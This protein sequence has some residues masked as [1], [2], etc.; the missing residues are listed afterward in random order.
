MWAWDGAT[1]SAAL[2]HLFFRISALCPANKVQ[3]QSSKRRR[4]VIP[5]G[6]ISA[7]NRGRREN[8]KEPPF[9]RKRRYA[10]FLAGSNELKKNY[11]PTQV[12]LVNI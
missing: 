6:T 10:P 2:A 9:P 3:K 1:G 11:A 8:P 12:N 4:S 7:E 5:V